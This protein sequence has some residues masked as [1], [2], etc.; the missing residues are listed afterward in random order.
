MQAKKIGKMR[1]RSRSAAARFLIKRSRK[2]FTVIAK[3]LGI[4]LPCVSQVAATIR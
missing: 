4:S 3:R 2:S 1:F